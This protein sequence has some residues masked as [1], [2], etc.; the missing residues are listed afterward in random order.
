LTETIPFLIREKAHERAA[1]ASRLS[2]RATKIGGHSPHEAS[3]PRNR[4]AGC[5]SGCSSGP[6]VTSNPLH[7]AARRLWRWSVFQRGCRRTGTVQASGPP[8][9]RAAH[10][11]PP[12]LLRLESGH[13][14]TMPT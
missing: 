2:R 12:P 4:L 14:C 10:W 3:T 5:R 9:S 13:Y 8:P 11:L 7:F 1:R 6:S